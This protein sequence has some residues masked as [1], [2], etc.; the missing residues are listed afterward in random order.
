MSDSEDKMV[1]VMTCGAD[2]HDRATI[3]FVMANAALAMD[4]EC[5]VILQASAVMLA[6]T[7]IAHHV[8]AP[9]LPP[10]EELLASYKEQGGRLY[11]CTPCCLSR[12]IEKGDLVDN[13]EMVT[14]G[15]VID[16]TTA[17]KT[18]LCY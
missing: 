3:A 17:A 11:V 14:S 6:R 4:V 12:K 16:E 7:G 5:K 13:A 15:F 1:I 18:V 10:L 9:N 2:D 8:H